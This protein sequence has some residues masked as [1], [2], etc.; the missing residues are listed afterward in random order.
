MRNPKERD[1]T[2]SVEPYRKLQ[3]FPWTFLVPL[4]VRSSTQVAR[5]SYHTTLSTGNPISRS[6]NISAISL[7]VFLFS[8][9]HS[10]DG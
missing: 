7:I 5:Y 8:C 9:A 3:P 10:L 6:G 4:P 1:N 2:T